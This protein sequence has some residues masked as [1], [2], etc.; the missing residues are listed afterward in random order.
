[1]FVQIFLSKIILP[2]IMV[3]HMKPI[4]STTLNFSKEVEVRTVIPSNGISIL[5]QTPQYFC[6][7]TAELLV[8]TTGYYL[9]SQEAPPSMRSV[10]HIA[11]CWT[12]GFGNLVV[13]IVEGIQAIGP[14]V[15]IPSAFLVTRLICSF[16]S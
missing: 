8:S 14:W 7:V 11:W 13:V 12:F 10:V 6:S 4:Y 1:M 15:N 2:K 9:V 16:Y 5:W 3:G